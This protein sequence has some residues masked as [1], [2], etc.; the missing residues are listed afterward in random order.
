LEA[1]FRALS[2]QPGDLSTLRQ[3]IC[4]YVDAARR[5]NIPIER[6]IVELKQIARRSE[7]R[8]SR[9]RRF[10]EPFAT[11]DELIKAVVAWCVQRYFANL[12]A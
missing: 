10:A 3:A 5:E 11:Q 12:P 6:V 9:Y 4:T 2:E 8:F 7:V 1:A